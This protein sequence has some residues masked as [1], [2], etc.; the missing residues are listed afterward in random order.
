[1]FDIYLMEKYITA[2]DD[3][4]NKLNKKTVDFKV[5]PKK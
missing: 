2:E 3:Q 5:S 1:M 4:K